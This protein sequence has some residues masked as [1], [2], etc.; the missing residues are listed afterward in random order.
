MRLILENKEKVVGFSSLHRLSERTPCK[1]PFSLFVFGQLFSQQFDA[2][3]QPCTFRFDILG[4]QKKKLL[5]RMTA[6]K[7]Y[8]YAHIYIY[9]HIHLKSL[10][11]SA[12]SQTLRTILAGL[13][14]I[15]LLQSEGST[16]FKMVLLSSTIHQN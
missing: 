8:S 16:L 15:R 2:H 3:K 7:Q 4:S 1:Q 14:Y 6:I 11:M 10:F 13:L 9:T 12:K 5:Q